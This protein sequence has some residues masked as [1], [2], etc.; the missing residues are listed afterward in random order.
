M[1]ELA[2][3]RNTKVKDFFFKNSNYI[4]ISILLVIIL[5]GGIYI[6]TAPLPFLKDVTTNNYTLGPDLDP[7]LFLRN[8]K[9]I[10]ENG[11]LP[12]IDNM[13][14]APL[15]FNNGM[16]TYLLP[17]TIAY[18]YKFL[19][20]F[21]P[22]ITIEYAANIYP[23]IAFILMII[24]FFLFVRKAFSGQGKHQSNIIALILEFSQN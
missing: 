6:R 23:V 2:E 22:G 18:L 5:F 15:G 4:Y 10:V 21:D 9:I 8:A 3:E 7:F 1:N 19:N 16:E 14:Y 13:R 17:Y 11:S 20:Y 12:A 24:F